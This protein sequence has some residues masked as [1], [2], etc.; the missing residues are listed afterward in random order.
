[1]KEQVNHPSHYNFSKIEVIDVIESWNLGFHLGN[2]VK[3]IA[4]AS[5][6]GHYTEDLEK[7]KWYLKRY[8][9]YLYDKKREMSWFK[10]L[11]S[12]DTELQYVSTDSKHY[13]YKV[14]SDWK[15]D[16]DLECILILIYHGQI[17]Q[18]IS[19]LGEY[20]NY[21]KYRKSKKDD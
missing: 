19:I 16:S 7:A 17:E 5:K 20:I 6:K 15:L 13:L 2:A 8:L 12:T 1:M 4:R 3:Y 18:S 9:E 21:L 10:K 14:I 11:F